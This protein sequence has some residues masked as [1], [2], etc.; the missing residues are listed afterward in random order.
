M[1]SNGGGAGQF[2]IVGAKRASLST[3][4]AKMPEDVGW[5][6]SGESLIQFE[7]GEDEG[8]DE[9]EAEFEMEA[10][11]SADEDAAEMLLSKSEV[12][13]LASSILDNAL[14]LIFLSDSKISLFRV[15]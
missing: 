2:D 14:V 4:R 13:L 3:A 11:E 10:D 6:T 5:Q 8:E 9:E 1:P 15:I 7:E 12:L